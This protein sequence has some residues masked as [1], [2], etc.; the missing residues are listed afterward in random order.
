MKTPVIE[1]LLEGF[2]SQSRYSS[3]PVAGS[4][5]VSCANSPR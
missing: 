1:N 5:T 2:P 3:I 4:F